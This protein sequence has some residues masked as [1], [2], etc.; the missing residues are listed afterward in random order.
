[1]DVFV[2]GPLAYLN[3]DG[4]KM[5][6]E[7]F[8]LDIGGAVV[9][10]SPEG[11]LVVLNRPIEFVLALKGSVP[12]LIQLRLKFRHSLVHCHLTNLQG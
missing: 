11:L 3:D 5:S 1:M 4:P 6:E 12:T 9:I 7:R 8:P 2:Q 10:L